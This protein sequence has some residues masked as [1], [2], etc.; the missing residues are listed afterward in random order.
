[1][2][3]I[4]AMGCKLSLPL[5]AGIPLSYVLLLHIFDHNSKD[6]NEPASLK[7]RF[8]A[9]AI[10]NAVSIGLTYYVLSFS[11]STPLSL[12]GFKSTGNL[13]SIVVP[14]GLTLTLY[15]GQILLMYYE[16]ELVDYFRLSSWGASFRQWTWWRD[17]V[18]A[19]VT[20][21][22]A[23]RGCAA[24][25][26]AT[27]LSPAQTIFIAPLSF[28]LSHMH[29]ID[30]DTKKGATLRDAVVGRAF[31]GA[32]TY[33][34]G[35]YATFLF[36][37]TG[38]IIAPMVTHSMCNGFGLPQLHEIQPLPKMRTLDYVRPGIRRYYTAL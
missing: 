13:A 2:S 20:E 11:S 19:P 28:A 31:Q 8:L 36:L 15:A 32:Y 18:V 26:M 4:G 30:D 33:I 6:K 29:H 12:M 37:R 14:A 23:F 5:S 34:F 27:C 22:I 38:N 16:K 10:N 1:M 21:E 35:A 17:I 25:L 9:A 24:A 3:L 7:K